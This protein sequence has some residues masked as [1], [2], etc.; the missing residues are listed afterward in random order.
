MRLKLT[1]VL[2][3]FLCIPVY[4]QEKNDKEISI[5]LELFTSQGCQACPPADNY[6]NEVVKRH[7]D[8]PSILPLAFHVDYW[9]QRGWKDPFSDSNSTAR[10][11]EYS[12]KFK[13]RGTYTPQF[14]ANGEKVISRGYQDAI[15]SYIAKNKEEK[16]PVSVE[17]DALNRFHLNITIGKN[18][19]NDGSYGDKDVWLMPIIYETVTQV[20]KG[21]NR[22]KILKGRNIV[23][24][25]IFLG[26]WRGGEGSMAI[27]AEKYK[28]YDAFAV[29]VQET[30]GG[31]ILGAGLY[32]MKKS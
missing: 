6:F 19:S 1:F 26:A 11:M 25:F 24:D 12:K 31:K 27:S 20:R 13:Q 17:F 7:S 9:N 22:G 15:P 4:A 32:E 3:L 14:I 23:K 2:I 18:L 16:L 21:P 28:D 5:V 10:Q 29:I 30:R 8:E